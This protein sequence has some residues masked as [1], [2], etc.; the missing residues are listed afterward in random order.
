MG[1][2]CRNPSIQAENG[3]VFITETRWW[4]TAGKT[5]TVYLDPSDISTYFYVLV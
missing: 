2:V 4:I 1:L 3:C 5:H